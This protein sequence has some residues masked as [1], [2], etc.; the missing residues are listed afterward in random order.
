MIYCTH[1]LNLKRVPRSPQNSMKMVSGVSTLFYKLPRNAKKFPKT[2]ILQ[3][4]QVI[5]QKNEF[6]FAAHTSKLTSICCISENE[7]SFQSWN[8]G[9]QDL[10][11]SWNL[12]RIIYFCIKMS[13][14]NFFFKKKQFFSSTVLRITNIKPE[15]KKLCMLKTSFLYPFRITWGYILPTAEVSGKCRFLKV[16]FLL[17]RTLLLKYN[18]S[19]FLRLSISA[20]AYN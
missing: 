20:R 4:I 3:A 12:P 10:S 11:Q 8:F 15:E 6:F 7:V 17:L 1:S 14:I 9:S 18:R 2:E 16:A 5:G 13:K 19:M